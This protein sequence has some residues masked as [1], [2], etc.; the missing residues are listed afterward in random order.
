MGM[1]RDRP[2][3]GDL[4]GELL[5]GVCVQ[6]QAHLVQKLRGVEAVVVHLGGHR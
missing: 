5:V 1:G 6:V 2:N 3:L 4:L